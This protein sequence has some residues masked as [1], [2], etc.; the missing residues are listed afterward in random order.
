MGETQML[1]AIVAVA[2]MA[3]I[4][5]ILINKNKKGDTIKWGK[6]L[7]I[8]LAMV[9]FVVTFSLFNPHRF[10]QWYKGEATLNESK[11]TC[12]AG[13]KA[14]AD[15][16]RFAGEADDQG[17]LY[18]ALQVKQMTPTGYYRT[19][20]PYGHA[21]TERSEEQTESDK[22]VIRHTTTRFPIT[23]NISDKADE[24]M[25]LCVA[26]LANHGSVLVAL[27]EQDI[28]SEGELPVA[29][30]RLTDEKLSEIALATD[31]TIIADYYFVAFDEARYNNNTTNYYLYKAIAG[32]IAAIVVA[33]VYLVS[34]RL[35]K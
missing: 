3:L 15:I 20:A 6:I 9:A 34:V 1:V 26:Q 14:G 31:S 16:P 27:E 23:R 11:T 2:I 4:G 35:K 24:Y 17:T 21:E 18:Y 22:T 7:S 28:V 32:L 13:R 33:V 25:P 5:R 12:I 19:K 29:M 8:T 30:M 10:I